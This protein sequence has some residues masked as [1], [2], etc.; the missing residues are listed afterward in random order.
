M[1]PNTKRWIRWLVIGG[2]AAY[3]IYGLV[4]GIMHLAQ[5]HDVPW[6]F[7]WLFLAPLIA[8]VSGVFLTIS[9]FTFA[10]QYRRLCTLI[11]AVTAVAVFGCII[12][13]PEWLG[14]TDWADPRSHGALSVVGGLLSI[15]ALVVAWYGAR[16]VYRRAHT[17]LL[18]YVQHQSHNAA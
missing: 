12:S 14:I 11:A 18:R 8:V 16:W 15:V 17:F 4:E 6:A 3:G 1:Q 5:Q 7:R 10:R 13:V 9:Y 2:F